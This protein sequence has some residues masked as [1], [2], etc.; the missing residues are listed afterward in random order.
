MM[1]YLYEKLFVKL[2]SFKF[3]FVV[4]SQN[5]SQ[6]VPFSG[7]PIVRGV[8]IWLTSLNLEV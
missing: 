2:A 8:K 5:I 4:K 1:N 7:R 6:K 3:Q